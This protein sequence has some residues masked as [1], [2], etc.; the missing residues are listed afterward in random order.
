MKSREDVKQLFQLFENG[1]EIPTIFQVPIGSRIDWLRPGIDEI[2]VNQHPASTS[3]WSEQPTADVAIP[4]L[5]FRRG[6]H[7]VPKIADKIKHLESE[8]TQ[9]GI[10][11]VFFFG[12]GWQTFRLEKR[13]HFSWSVFMDEH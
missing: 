1:M 8:A 12:G 13:K 7:L 5:R 11:S 3:M 6:G 2:D 10:Q 9:I 4:T